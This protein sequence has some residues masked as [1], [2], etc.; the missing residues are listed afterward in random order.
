MDF[1][2]S[3]RTD[4]NDRVQQGLIYYTYS[5]VRLKPRAP[6]PGG[7]PFKHAPLSGPAVCTI[8]HT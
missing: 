2:F 3:K 7:A 5:L 6:G 8:I 1:K 4:L